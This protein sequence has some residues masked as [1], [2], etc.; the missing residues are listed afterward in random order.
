MQSLVYI[1]IGKT[2][3][4]A[5]RKTLESAG[6]KCSDPFAQNRMSEAEAKYYDQFD[7]ICGHISRA[8]QQKWFGNRNVIT[9]LREPI[10]RC[11]SAIHYFR[12]PEVAAHL[13]H[14]SLSV[15]EVIE[16]QAGIENT[17]NTMVRQLGGHMLDERPDFPALLACAKATVLASIW[18]GFQDTMRHDI[19]RLAALVGAPLRDTIANVTPNRPP[20]E[21]EDPRVIARLYELNGYDLQLW[22]WARG[23]H[24][25][26]S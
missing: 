21:A 25:A 6:I 24:Q 18:V 11:L 16:T 9:T 14:D 26:A 7:A 4:T 17:H 13:G 22:H 23:L 10:D 15:A 5:L 1:H 12:T 3:G 20:L 19:E 8:D 2:G